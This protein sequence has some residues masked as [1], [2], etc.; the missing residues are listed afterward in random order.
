MTRKHGGDKVRNRLISCCALIQ[1]LARLLGE[2]MHNF[3]SCAFLNNFSSMMQYQ[4]NDCWE[5]YNVKLSD[6]TLTFNNLVQTL[7]VIINL[8]IFIT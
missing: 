3:L 1:D 2:L 4:L 7:C 5:Y 6:R 8:V